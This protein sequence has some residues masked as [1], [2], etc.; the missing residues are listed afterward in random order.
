GLQPNLLPQIREERHCRRSE[1]VLKF[2]QEYV[3]ITRQLSRNRRLC[4]L[5]DV[6]VELVL[7]PVIQ[8][9]VEAD[10]ELIGAI[11]VSWNKSRRV[12]IQVVR[13]GCDRLNGGVSDCQPPSSPTSS[14][15]TLGCAGTKQRTPHSWSTVLGLFFASE[16]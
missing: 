13:A 10:C 7:H 4:D 9:P 5:I 15:S 16:Y 3:N 8:V 1:T 2:L 6:E 14:G 12:E 11:A